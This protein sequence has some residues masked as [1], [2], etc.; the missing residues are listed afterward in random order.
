MSV[1][2]GD[3]AEW[4]MLACEEFAQAT[5]QRT[6]D[7][8]HSIIVDLIADLL[9]LAEIEGLC[10]ERVITTAQMH[11]DAERNEEEN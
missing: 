6:Q 4:A 5:G 10:S 11:F 3:R 9:H 8:L 7:E 1:T 2:N